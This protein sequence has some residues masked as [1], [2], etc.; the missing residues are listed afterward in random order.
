MP[1]VP[2]LGNAA[3]RPGRPVMAAADP[4]ERARRFDP[5]VRASML[6]VA[7]GTGIGTAARLGSPEAARSA[8]QRAIARAAAD[9]ALR[10]V[11]DA[12]DRALRAAT[13]A[14]R[15]ADDDAWVTA[16]LAKRNAYVR[17]IAEMMG[18]D[19]GAAEDAVRELGWPAFLTSVGLG[20]LAL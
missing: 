12:Y 3:T 9:P 13:P 10:T 5:A 2:P 11:V 8:R 16:Q 19:P 7:V 17:K 1:R 14:Y 18:H 6:A 20:R 15:G 4:S